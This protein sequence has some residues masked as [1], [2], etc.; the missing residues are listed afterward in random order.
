[1]CPDQRHGRTRGFAAKQFTLGNVVTVPDLLR[2]QPDCA[3]ASLE[4]AQQSLRF[5]KPTGSNFVVRTFAGQQGPCTSDPASI[6]RPA[7]LMLA[8][9]IF[10]IAPP[11]GALWQVDLEQVIDHPHGV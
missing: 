9:A 2:N 6:K 10:V 1:M 5:V 8:I 4:G 11:D 3:G 7:V